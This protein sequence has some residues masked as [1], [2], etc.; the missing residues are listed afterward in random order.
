MITGTVCF[1][2]GVIVGAV[3]GYFVKRNNEKRFTAMETKAERIK[4]AIT[5]K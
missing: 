1:I 5:N 3:A 4:T 2:G